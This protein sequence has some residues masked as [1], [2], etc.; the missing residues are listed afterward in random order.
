M[1]DHCF[2]TDDGKISFEKGKNISA[3]WAKLH[4]VSLKCWK[5]YI[6]I[7]AFIFGVFTSFGAVANGLTI[8]PERC[9][10][11]SWKIKQIPTWVGT[12]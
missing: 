11:E 6:M 4:V 5:N 12:L 3:Q 7:E 1:E 8:F 2:K 10:K 9:V